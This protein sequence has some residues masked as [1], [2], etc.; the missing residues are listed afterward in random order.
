MNFLIFIFAISL[1]TVPICASILSNLTSDEMKNK[2]LEADTK[3]IFSFISK[4]FVIFLIVC[5]MKLVYKG[6]SSEKDMQSM[7]LTPL[8]FTILISEVVYVN[9]FSTRCLKFRKSIMTFLTETEKFFKSK[10]ALNIIFICLIIFMKRY[11]NLFIGLV[12]SY[13]FF[14][15]TDINKNY[16]K[17]KNTD[18]KDEGVGLLQQLIQTLLNILLLYSFVSIERIYVD[19]MNGNNISISFSDASNLLSFIIVIVINN[20][21]LK[22]IQYFFKNKNLPFKKIKRG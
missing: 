11:T 20:F 12:G 8:Y 2:E 21:Y 10:F 14:A 5:F 16:E 19:I 1:F 9:Y 4:I 3:K 7:F 15:L 6:E 13:I 18:Y 22:I 17:S